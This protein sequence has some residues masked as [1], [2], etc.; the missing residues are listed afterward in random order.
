MTRVTAGRGKRVRKAEIPKAPDLTREE[1]IALGKAARAEVP[2]SSH[3]EFTPAP[4][5][6]DP[7][8]LLENQG[9]A[10]VPELLPIRYGR[11]AVSAFTVREFASTYASPMPTRTSETTE[12]WSTPSPRAV[13]PRMRAYRMLSVPP[14]G[15]AARPL[16]SP[17]TGQRLR[18]ADSGPSPHPA[19]QASTGDTRLAPRCSPRFLSSP[20]CDAP[21]APTAKLL[22]SL[23]EALTADDGHA[24]LLL[25]DT[26]V[27]LHVPER[28]G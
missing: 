1:R 26:R 19:G 5:R 3:A 27:E 12:H 22:V 10:R 8:A 23:A 11:M 7:V 21:S 4:Q 24:K 25:D 17:R 15:S 13:S 20:G 9:T 6:P 2:R 16:T 18:K 28:K 14:P